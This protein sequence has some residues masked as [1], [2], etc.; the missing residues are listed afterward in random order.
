MPLGLSGEF[1]GEFQ[2]LSL[3][4]AKLG[5]EVGGINDAL[6]EK[7]TVLRCR[8]YLVLY[9]VEFRQHE[10][11]AGRYEAYVGRILEDDCP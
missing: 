3:G 7:A 4:L 10:L 2:T 8:L 5:V 1:G 11:L 9:V 6:C